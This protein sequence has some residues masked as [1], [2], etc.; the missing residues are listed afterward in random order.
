MTHC[1]PRLD[2][3][4]F[5]AIVDDGL[6]MIALLMMLL[7]ANYY[8]LTQIKAALVKAGIHTSKVLHAFRVGGAGHLHNLG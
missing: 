4:F 7:K 5:V 3:L 6:M 8:H 2:I 1:T